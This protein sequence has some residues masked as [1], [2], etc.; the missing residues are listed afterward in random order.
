MR[1]V[2]LVIGV[3][4]LGIG[5]FAQ[6]RDNVLEQQWEKENQEELRQSKV[7]EEQAK[8]DPGRAVVIYSRPEDP[9]IQAIE[10][11]ELYLGLQPVFIYLVGGVVVVVGAVL[12]WMMRRPKKAATTAPQASTD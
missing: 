7:R 11:G 9:R 6:Y 1:W 2:I 12:A 3:L 10:N 5:L 4:V 8:A